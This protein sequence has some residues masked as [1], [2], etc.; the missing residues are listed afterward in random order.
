MGVLA[1][2]FALLVAASAMAAMPCG[3]EVR[4]ETDTGYYL[5]LPPPDWDGKSPL[6]LVVFFHGWNSSPEEMLANRP[7]IH[8]VHERGALL[9]LP[10]AIAGYWRQIGPGR[11]EP[12]RDERAFI[13]EVMDDVARRWPV[14]RHRTLAAGF[15]R[16]ASMV[17][18]V[19]C[20]VP[21]LF[22][23]F[24]AIAGGFWDTT[25]ADCPAGPVNLRHIHG[26]RDRVVPFDVP[27][28]YG[29]AP[30][31][32]GL[33]LL[34]RVNGCTGA[35]VAMTGNGRLRCQ[36]WQGCTSGHVIELCRHPGGHSLRAE[37]VGEG[38]DW[39]DEIS[40]R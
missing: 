21:G 29:S 35:P 18:N 15:S 2:L 3:G 20:Y 38:L 32:D 13:H 37:W 23:G 28:P 30:V 5:A 11:A 8:G 16:G 25:P 4:C 40:A 24:L 19:A 27:G 22:R 17:W 7:L 36:R 1:A 26:R 33:A 12:G 10:W 14:D 31:P 34:R 9:V 39:L 6:P